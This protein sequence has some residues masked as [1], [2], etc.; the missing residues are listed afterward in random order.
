MQG[1]IY[2]LRSATQDDH[3]F[4]YGAWIKG[5]WEAP[6]NR[7]CPWQLFKVGYAERIG[8]RLQDKCLV[9]CHPDDPDA[10]MGFV[11]YRKSNEALIVHWLYVIGMFRRQGLAKQV[12]TELGGSPVLTENSVHLTWARKKGCLYDPFA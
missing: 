4:I 10:L 3:P 9:L 1:L 2:V 11:C 7:W 6:P 12:L 8:Q 5:T